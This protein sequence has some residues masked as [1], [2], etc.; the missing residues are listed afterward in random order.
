MS[1]KRKISYEQDK[2]L[3]AGRDVAR[4]N[5]RRRVAAD[6]AADKA[7]EDRERREREH[8][9]RGLH[10]WKNWEYDF[11]T[12][13]ETRACRECGLSETRPITW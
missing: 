9:E 4:A 1:E 13:T 5:Q 10:G 6:R 3:A 2:A 8:M 11:E 12:M 7:R